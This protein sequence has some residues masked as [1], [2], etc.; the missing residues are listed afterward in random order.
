MARHA[1]RG[2]E[3]GLTPLPGLVAVKQYS[4]VSQGGCDGVSL[5]VREKKLSKGELTLSLSTRYI[6][7]RDLELWERQR[8]NLIGGRSSCLQ[9]PYALDRAHT[10]QDINTAPTPGQ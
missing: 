6:G 9:V 7:P 5:G 1:T 4:R 3:A 8:R 10:P 2:I